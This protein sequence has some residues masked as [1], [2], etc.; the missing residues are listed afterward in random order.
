MAPFEAAILDVDGTIVRGDALLPGA[1]DGLRALDAAG[2]PRLLFSNNPTR[3]AAHYG[4]RLGDHGIEVD[5][6]NV[7][8]SATVTAEYLAANHADD[9]IYLLGESRLRAI[10]ETRDLVVTAEPT[11]ADVVLGSIDRGLSYDR[12]GEAQT[13]LERGV[14]FYGTDPD[15]TIPTE[16]GSMPGS[17][18]I[19]GALEAIAG[20]PPDAVLGKPSDVAAAAAIDRLGVP[21]ERTLVV[22]DRLDTDVELGRRAD[23]TTALV[24][25]GLTS[26]ADV[27]DAAAGPD[28]VLD[29][30]AEIAD[31]LD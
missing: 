29:S 15:S 22:G 31:L 20:R 19:L 7:L 16:N 30:L 24:T 21:P 4:D 14:P 1:V 13:A 23:M 18:A 8:T 12:L 3:G 2:V 9:A 17:G 5:P 28:Y 11:A 27:A 6:R 10:L 26:R 25:T